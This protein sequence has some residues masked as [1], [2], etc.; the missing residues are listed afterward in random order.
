MNRIWFAF[1]LS[2]EFQPFTSVGYSTVPRP[3]AHYTDKNERGES[4]EVPP[5]DYVRQLWERYIAQEW[6][7]WARKASIART[8]K[9]SYQKLFATGMNL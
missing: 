8:V 5:D 9:G 1:S 2:T 7:E 3:F 4:V 6:T